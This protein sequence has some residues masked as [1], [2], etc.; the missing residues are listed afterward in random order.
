M[1]ELGLEFET[2]DASLVL[3]Q[4]LL[5]VLAYFSKSQGREA[6]FETFCLILL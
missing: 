1:A 3:G 6:Y 4:C 5:N 2:S